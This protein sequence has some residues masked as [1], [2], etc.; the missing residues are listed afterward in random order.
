VSWAGWLEPLP[1]AATMRAIDAW[2]IE[3]RGIPGLDL[4]DRAG[5][6]LAAVTA[7]TITAGRIAVVCGRGNNGGDG[8]VAARVLRGAGREV[9]VLLLTDPGE[10]SVDAAEQLRRLGGPTAARPWS[11]EGLAGAAGAIDAILGT[12]FHGAPRG[13]AAEAIGA[14]TGLGAPVVAADVP[15][16]VDA[17]S[18]EVAGVAVRAKVTVAFHAA[19]LGHWVHPGKALAGEVRVVD[20]GIPPQAPQRIDAGLIGDGVLSGLPARTATSTKFTSGTVVVVGGSTGL[21]GAPTMATLAAQ[22][23]GAGYV[24]VAGPASL[25]LAFATRLLEAMFAGLPEAGGH[26]DTDAL[27]AVLARC[28]RASA[29]VVGP[30]LGRSPGTQALV[31]TLVEQVELPLVL[32]ADGLNALGTDFATSL[33][34]RD[35]GT[36]LTP[37]A[38]ELGRLLGV[39]SAD[40]DRARLDH[41]RRAAREAGAI[42]VLKGDDTL[43]AMPDG[44]VAVSAGGAPGL[45]TAGTGD[46]LAGVVGALLA[47]GADPDHAVCAAVHAHRRAGR[48]AGLQHGDEHVIASDVIAALP[49]ALRP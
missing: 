40:V 44:R 22:R 1:D 27:E 10:L 24:T 36:V 13:A 34:R 47:R 16:G 11:S 14:L 8:L 28:E 31:R 43:V 41:A 6:T 12:G 38:G 4:M 42:V 18:G 33:R 25:E 5:E 45:A 30:G 37:H 48:L 32:D 26:L 15:S 21:T 17:S 29:V 7:E 46:V 2:A 20:I 49:R 19:K 35:A 9:D 39:A 23:A 3:E